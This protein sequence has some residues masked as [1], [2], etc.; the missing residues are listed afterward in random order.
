MKNIFSAVGVT[1]AMAIFSAS[2]VADEDRRMQVNQ[3]SMRDADA[4]VKGYEEGKTI[5]FDLSSEELKEEKKALMSALS[6]MVIG[7]QKMVYLKKGPQGSQFL[8]LEKQMRTEKQ[9]RAVEKF[10]NA[11]QPSTRTRRSVSTRAATPPL[12]ESGTLK[13]RVNTVTLRKDNISCMLPRYTGV[14]AG[15]NL[16]SLWRQQQAL[17]L[18][19]V[20]SDYCDGEADMELN[21][22]IDMFGSKVVKK[23]VNGRLISTEAGKYFVVTVS[24]DAQAGSGWHIADDLQRQRDF[25]TSIGAGIPGAARGESL[26]PLVNR[27][28]FWIRKPADTEVQLVEKFP[29][30]KERQVSINETR[31]VVAGITGTV[32]GMR[33]V[34]NAV[35]GSSSNTSGSSSSNTNGSASSNSNGTS[36][37][38]TNGTSSGSSHETN[39]STAVT[40]G[41][42]SSTTVT[43]GSKDTNTN[44]SSNSTTTGTNVTNGNSNSNSN[45]NSSTNANNSSNTTAATTNNSTTGQVTSQLAGAIQQSNNRTLSYTGTE[46]T[47]E[48]KSSTKIAKWIWA[49]RI[50]DDRERIC[51]FLVKKDLNTCFYTMP[52]LDSGWI[53]NANKF[54]SAT[55][56]NFVPA[57][58]AVFKAAPKFAKTSTFEFGAS[59]EL[60]SFVGATQPAW[61]PQLLGTSGNVVPGVDGMPAVISSLMPDIQRFSADLKTGPVQSVTESF[62]VD[63]DQP[64]FSPE[65]NI[66]LQVISTPVGGVPETFNTLCLSANFNANTN[67][68]VNAGQ[69]VADAR[70]AAQAAVSAAGIADNALAQAIAAEAVVLAMLQAND[71]TANRIAYSEAAAVT[72]ARRTQKTAADVAVVRAGT[73]V[74]VAEERAVLSN[75]KVPTATFEQC[76]SKK[77]QVWG[78]DAEEKLFKSRAVKGGEY[79]LAYPNLDGRLNGDDTLVV[80]PERNAVEIWPCSGLDNRQKW[81]LQDDGYL[82][83]YT[84]TYSKLLGYGVELQKAKDRYGDLIVQDG[85]YVIERLPHTGMTHEGNL[86]KKIQAFPVQF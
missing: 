5:L 25:S 66:R 56:A 77:E 8:V 12:D 36:I 39:T 7:D 40:T 73:A 65:A 11:Q 1:T 72:A 74:R 23:E 4:I 38:T 52:L 13:P 71:T 14:T 6:G 26:G 86:Q 31:G 9:T 57:F 10:E 83:T 45:S 70:T 68:N 20:D 35:G 51:D 58:Q 32:T 41:E 37:G 48:N 79:C 69:V 46:Y 49:L 16:L 33:N 60:A 76:N 55:H 63:W 81:I 47:I 34:N 2:S 53:I 29:A 80:T 28:Q 54:S 24:P 3:D 18:T 82:R 30:N 21:Y 19:S 61:S 84:G 62:T 15:S 50:E 75:A 78:Y 44:G 59:V 22:Q 27:Y 43:N 42:K 85:K 67:A 17:P 64:Y